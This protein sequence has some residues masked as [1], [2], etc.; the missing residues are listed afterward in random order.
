MLGNAWYAL[1]Q[2][3]EQWRRLHACPELTEQAMEELLR[4]AGLTRL[5]AREAIEE[6]DLDG[7]RIPKGQRIILR[8]VAG[9]HDPQRFPDPEVVDVTRSSA[10]H[11][12]LGAGAHSCVGA[13]LIRMSL[14]AV[15]AP[16]LRRFS[17]A[18]PARPVEWKGGAIFQSPQSLWVDFAL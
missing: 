13:S 9:N 7:C 3:P 8:I 14:V 12:A 4:Y 5:I 10:G 18:S 2:H 6:I 1:L 15:T 11:L 16:L 17:S